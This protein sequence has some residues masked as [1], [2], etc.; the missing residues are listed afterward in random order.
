MRRKPR[1]RKP[2][3]IGNRSTLQSAAST[4]TDLKSPYQ[5]LTQ[6]ELHRI[7]TAALEL[8][9]TVGIADATERVKNIALQHGCTLSH[10]NRLLFPPALIEHC[11]DQAAKRFP[12]HAR[13]RSLSFE[14]VNDR[15]NFC[16][17]G[18][19]VSMLD[20]D[21]R[22][23]RPSTLRDLYDLARLCDTL[24]NIQWF[25][26]PIV[27]TDIEDSFELDVNTVYAC[28]AGTKK[29]I[30][31]SF[32]QAAHMHKLVPMFDVLAGGPGQFRQRPF[33]TVH[34]T[35]IVS[36]MRFA[37]DSLDIACAAI[38]IGMPIHLQTGPQ[39]GATAPAALA[40]TLV[41]VC[42]ETLASL[43]VVNM[44]KPGH[45]VVLGM[46]VMVSDL[47]TGAFSGGGAEQALLGAAAGQLIRYYGIPGGMGAGM[48]DSK[49]PDNQAGFE[50]ALTVALAAIS[51]GGFVLESAGMLGGLLGCSMEAMIIDNEMLWG[52]RRIARGIE[53]TDE[54]LSVEVIR[55]VAD[56]PGH[57]LGTQQTLELMK[58]EFHYPTL[59]DR[60][61]PDDW[62]QSGSQDIWTRSTT[63][64]R[65]I[66]TSH[67]PCYIDEKKDRYLRD[68]YSIHLS[69]P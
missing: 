36:P 54:T 24:D 63:R 65:E 38:D 21:T 20:I 28:A 69:K 2:A 47:R 59:A 12:V 15:V 23:Y 57:F 6:H 67:H 48:S 51:G 62:A 50:K 45:P 46:W 3:A 9:Q 41:Q 32:T 61:S 25:T 27:T 55:Q 35:T 68:R 40:G 8:L 1:K 14:A 5:P 60:R 42:A 31:S 49:L 56:N 64:A 7:H 53:V 22:Q 11:I 34:A 26:R 18:A 37:Q 33:C 44:F 16:T 4:G 13:D 30:A 58:T 52:I 19:A 43:A 66:L 10:N 29:H 17:G 39:A